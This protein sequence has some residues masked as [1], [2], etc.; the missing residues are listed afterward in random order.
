LK[1]TLRASIATSIAI[2]TLI[3]ALKVTGQQNSRSISLQGVKAILDDQLTPEGQQGYHP[4][5]VV[6]K[7]VDTVR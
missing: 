7:I 2:A 3:K 1:D 4:F 5:W 6:P